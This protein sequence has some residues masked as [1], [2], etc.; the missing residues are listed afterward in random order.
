MNFQSH[1][2]EAEADGAVSPA[3]GLLTIRLHAVCE[4]HQGI[5]DHTDEGF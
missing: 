4:T 5:K 2:T 1:V 3:T